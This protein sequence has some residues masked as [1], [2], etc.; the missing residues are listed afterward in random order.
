MKIIDI[1]LKN[2]NSLR[3][4]W[5]IDFSSGSYASDGIF[6]ITGPTGA[7]KT[8]IFDA[9]CLALYGQT[10]RL[11]RIGGQN[12]EIM[13]KHTNECYAQVIFETGGK[14]YLCS[15]E[16]HKA[17]RGGKLQQAKHIISEYPGSIIAEKISDT[18]KAV[19]AVTGMDF[20]RFT[21]AVMLE[22]GGF[23]AFLKAN[24]AERSQILELLT[25]TEIYGRIS[26]LVYER[27]DTERG[28]LEELRIK[29][30]TLKP[31]D[32]Y[33]TDDEIR[34]ELAR[35]QAEFSC[36][37][38]RHN[39]MKAAI[40]WLKNIAVIRRDIDGHNES[41][42]GLMKQSEL[43]TADSR[44]LDAALRAR[45]LMTPYTALRAKRNHFGT[46]REQA[47]RYARYIARNESRLADI[48]TIELPER[49]FE[50]KR[51]VQNIAY[52]DTPEAACARAK[53]QVKAYRDYACKT[54]KLEAAKLEAEGNLSKAQAVMLSAE[55]EYS[56]V[57]KRHDE[58]F[59]RRMQRGLKDGEPCPV[60]GSLE[61]PAVIHAESYGEADMMLPDFEAVSKRLREA[62]TREGIARKILE[63]STAMLNENA[64]AVT[65]AKAKVRGL[66]EPLGIFGA[67]NVD[68]MNK[69]LDK[70]LYEVRDY[71]AKIKSLKEQSSQLHAGIEAMKRT[72]QEDNS[73]ID[74]MTGE[75]ETMQGD[76]A[77][78]LREK[79]FD[80]EEHFTA[81]M[82][83]DNDIASLQERKTYID[84]S[85]KQLQAVIA[86]RTEK[87]TAEQKKNITTQTL[88]ELSPLFR[89]DEERINTL[90]KNIYSLETKLQE[91]MKL[92]QELEELNTQRIRQE[93]IYSDWSS[94]NALIGQRD[95]GK[96]R[97][98]AQSITLR[99]MVGL[100]NTQ[101][102]KLSGRYSLTTAPGDDG[103]K[104]C[105]IDREQ[106][107]EIRPTENLSGG[108][109]F[110]ISLAL[111]LGLSQISGS[112]ARV[113]SLFLDEGFG[114]L[115]D[116]ALSTALEALGE[117]RREG[118][119]IGIISHVQ[120]LKDRIAAQINVIPKREGV[121]ILEGAGCS[122][123]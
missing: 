9:V 28:K 27:A 72:L 108:E 100:A 121:S 46:I 17:G 24:A 119:M 40:D 86:E 38:S 93:K 70:W 89:Q 81:S 73:A 37:E 47:E 82:M 41:L 69:A 12:N 29:M 78:M 15:W 71:D 44:R 58:V 57:L 6:A 22:Q 30:D 104:L 84:D 80:S 96:F 43:F 5:H 98:F 61:H 77:A 102:E 23:D 109:R 112:R 36:L 83:R 95:G 39:D 99:M 76:F 107:G 113:D 63:H 91:R 49:E 62:Q 85:M 115:D 52:G 94:L 50:Y 14:K 11:G 18:L 56:A 33:G 31:R 64:E 117:V 75:L 101:L 34:Q 87:L 105:V 123:E 120:A 21:Q 19:E 2:L 66:V 110:I 116:D 10:P 60:C 25:G 53:A 13:S 45:E 42:A 79:A 3:G 48:E 97:K 54:P 67:R 74:T 122:R 4:E 88:E 90:R 20:R 59:I 8:T 111:A 103:L 32:N 7:G 118:R 26:A 35:T 16:Q 65:D 55:R 114:S 1:R 51:R 68:E 92:Q 106:A